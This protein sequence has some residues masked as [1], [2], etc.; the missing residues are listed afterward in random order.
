VLELTSD[1]QSRLAQYRRE[2]R[3]A[4]LRTAPAD[5]EAVADAVRR[6]YTS[7]GHPVPRF[8]LWF[9]SPL[10]A[11]RAQNLLHLEQDQEFF[12]S[13]RLQSSRL[14]RES[15]EPTREKLLAITGL[16]N[17]E[18]AR[19]FLIPPPPQPDGQ[20]P[21]IQYYWLLNKLRKTGILEALLPTGP[22]YYAR[23]HG[24]IS[25]AP[26]YKSKLVFTSHDNDP[27]GGFQEDIDETD[28]IC[29]HA[30]GVIER[31]Q[32]S[33][34]LGEIG[35]LTA[36]ADFTIRHIS[37]GQLARVEFLARE[38]GQ[39]IHESLV[40][41]ADIAKQTSLCWSFSTAILFCETPAEIHRNAKGELH[42][43]NGPALVY[44]DGWSV[45]ALKGKLTDPLAFLPADQITFDLI[46]RN[47]DQKKLL[48]KRYGRERY[49]Q[50]L[51][52]RKQ[53]RDH[54]ILK[55]QIPQSKPERLEL[56]RDAAG[57]ALP[58]YDRYLAG[59]R[60]EVWKELRQLGRAARGQQAPDVLAV[61]YET[62]ERVCGNIKLLVERLH[63]LHYE[64]EHSPFEE[65]DATSRGI[66]KKIDR[67]PG[68]LPL[69]LRVFYDLIGSVTFIGHHELLS[70]RS[71]DAESPVRHLLTD[72]LTAFP[73][74]S[75]L[76]ES[77]GGDP[78]VASLE[79]IFEI[80]PDRYHKHDISG[81]SPYGF[82]LPCHEADAVLEEEQNDLYFVDYLRLCFRHG[83][84]PGFESETS[85]IP[86]RE[87]EFLTKDLIEI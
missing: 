43:E 21:N 26:G 75:C 73:V 4:V 12:E 61:A 58:F 17:W 8:Q 25:V 77:E 83:G 50:E 62:M 15:V 85:L 78:E 37:L 49:K 29:F 47:P 72:P 63:K 59:D 45:Y 38:C 80:A 36:G 44:R 24:P 18:D 48:I 14:F 82:H 22:R 30:D 19:Q 10:D 16:T 42:R 66:L 6:L 2:W 74:E 51:A 79:Y 39:P 5:R 7:L 55:K 27:L 35:G 11:A 1:Q 57:G 54:P 28:W 56:L 69:S 84:F 40:A 13:I 53:L 33:Q 64:F 34:T 81:G 32:L 70:W 68:P 20:G 9:E 31:I 86:P 46:Q 87:M 60:V 71:G 41:L 67:K 76:F 3:V 52:D 23:F 65:P